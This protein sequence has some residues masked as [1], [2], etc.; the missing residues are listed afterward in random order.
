M[1][2]I[3]PNNFEF[4][5]CNLRSFSKLFDHVLLASRS[6]FQNKK[7]YFFLKPIFYGLFIIKYGFGKKKI[8][9]RLILEHIRMKTNIP[10]ASISWNANV[11]AARERT[12]FK[13]RSTKGH[14]DLWKSQLKK[15]RQDKE[16]KEKIQRKLHK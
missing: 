10:I 16:I 5:L 4:K 11:E 15:Q 13:K 2:D 3:F 12:P 14:N 1:K 6:I 9:F 8:F 7:E